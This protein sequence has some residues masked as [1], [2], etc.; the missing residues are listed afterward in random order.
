MNVF[1][2]LL[3]EL[4]EISGQNVNRAPQPKPQRKAPQKKVKPQPQ[5]VQPKAEPKRETPKVQEVKQEPKER[6]VAGVPINAQTVRQGIIMSEILGK[7]LC[8]RR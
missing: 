4:F 6:T 3:K 7:P 1:N 5:A 8:K 2:P